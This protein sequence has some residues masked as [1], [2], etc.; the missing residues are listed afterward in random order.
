MSVGQNAEVIEKMFE[1]GGAGGALDATKQGLDFG[2][3]SEQI[4]FPRAIVVNRSEAVGVEVLFISGFERGGRGLVRAN[5]SASACEA[6]N[7]ER[8]LA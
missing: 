2:R 3:E 1:F 7:G 6:R 4:P 5:F 8:R